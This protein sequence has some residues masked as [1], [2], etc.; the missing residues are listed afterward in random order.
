LKLKDS[1]M[2]E[3][4]RTLPT[5]RGIIEVQ[6]HADMRRIESAFVR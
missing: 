1:G 2:R 4:A 6:G 5:V 3:V